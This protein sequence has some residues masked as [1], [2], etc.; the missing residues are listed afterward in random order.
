[1]S[2]KSL[3]SEISKKT[4]PVG[5][6]KVSFDLWEELNN[7]NEIEESNFCPVGSPSIE[8]PLP[9]LKGTKIVVWLDP[10]LNDKYFK[11]PPNSV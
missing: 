9:V 10:E 7:K 2:I 1:M 11:L 5:G 4:N 8:I 6:V 3:K